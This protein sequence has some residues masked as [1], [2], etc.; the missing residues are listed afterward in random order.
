MKNILLTFLVLAGLFIVM[1]CVSQNTTTQTAQQAAQQQAEQQAQ[2]AAQQ[3]A[4]QQAAQQTA[5]QQAQQALQN[6]S[7]PTTFECKVGIHWGGANGMQGTIIGVETYK[8]KQACHVTYSFSAEAK[9]DYYIDMN[10]ITS[11]CYV[12]SGAVGTEPTEVCNWQ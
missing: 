12:M 11:V 9:F 6:Q 2:Q 8:G 10:D 7:L 5:Q 4:Q 3:A 1:G